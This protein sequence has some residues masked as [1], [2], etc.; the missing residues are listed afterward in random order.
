MYE[1]IVGP[2]D[3]NHKKYIFSECVCVCGESKHNKIVYDYENLMD[4]AAL[5]F[6]TQTYGLFR[7][8][9]FLLLLF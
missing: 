2:D 3:A 8:V 1:I 6:R 9:N 4:N 7:D 5:L